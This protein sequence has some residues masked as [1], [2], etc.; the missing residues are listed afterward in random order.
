MT[1]VKSFILY[2]K[3]WECDLEYLQSKYIYFM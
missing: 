2:F 3:F 1:I